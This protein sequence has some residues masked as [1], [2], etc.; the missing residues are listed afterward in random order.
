MREVIRFNFLYRDSGNYKKFGSK[1]FG[2][3]DQL[4]YEEIE[5]NIIENLIDQEFFYPDQVGIKKIEFRNYLDENTWYEYE[6]IEIIVANNP[7]LKDLESIG[8]LILNLH[9]MKSKIA[10]LMIPSSPNRK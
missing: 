3:P 5:Q 1:I 6:S 4:S 8:N 7:P 9:H 2:N 10:N